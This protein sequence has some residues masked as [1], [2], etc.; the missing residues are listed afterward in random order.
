MDASL[1]EP[2]PSPEHPTTTDPAPERDAAVVVSGLRKRFGALD[3]LDGL[4]L[5]VPTGSIFGFLGPNGAGKT[6]TIRALLG[7]VRA[8]GGTMRILGHDVPAALPELRG[9]I[10]VVIDRPTPYPA[11]SGRRNLQVVADL[12]GGN[13]TVHDRID[14]V[15]SLVGLDRAADRPASGYSFG[16]RQRLA[17]AMALLPRPQL[18]IL[19][20]PANGLD[21]AGQ[22]DLRRVLAEA[23]DDGVTLLLSSHLL[24]EVQTLCDHVAILDRG[25]CIRAGTVDELLTEVHPAWLVDPG[26]DGAAAAEVLRAAG[27]HV[28]AADGTRLLVEADEP[29]WITWHL[30]NAGIWLRELRPSGRDLES[31]FLSLTATADRGHG[32][33]GGAR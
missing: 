7:L 10:G 5:V 11:L 18:L 21:P 15:L 33:A 4:D 12:T 20:E 9:R 1:A 8:D 26:P 25:R 27:L 23:R 2:P 30:G 14:P 24:G 29:G 16:M 6:T 22:Q 17:L 13:R 32:G 28:V 19:D 31:I 3:V